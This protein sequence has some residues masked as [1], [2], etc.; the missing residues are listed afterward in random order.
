L[1]RRDFASCPW[2]ELRRSAAREHCEASGAFPE[3]ARFPNAF[4][5]YDANN[6]DLFAEREILEKG[7]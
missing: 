4:T 5:E 7:A 1:V 6:R 3:R 2:V